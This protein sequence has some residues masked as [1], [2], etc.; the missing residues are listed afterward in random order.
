M[1]CLLAISGQYR[2]FEKTHQNILDNVIN[3][4][5]DYEFEIILNTDLENRNIFT[6][7]G[8]FN[9]TG[10]NFERKEL[11]SRLENC[12][13]K[14]L[15]HIIYYNIIEEDRSIPGSELFFKRNSLV[16]NYIEKNNLSYDRIICIRFDIEISLP[17]NLN[18]KNKLI[19]ICGEQRNTHR[20]D[21]VS[22]WDLCFLTDDII[23]LKVFLG[24]VP[25][26]SELTY[27]DLI[28][29]SSKINFVTGYLN[30][31]KDKKNI[32]EEGEGAWVLGFWRKFYDLHLLGFCTDFK[33]D[34]YAT[35][36][37]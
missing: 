27:N 7:D 34:I 9:F 24:I 19:F 29:F 18:I 31:V 15:K 21:H 3:C 25:L 16:I 5:P 6:Y 10:E 12:Y 32:I 26:S 14:Y 11:E 22:D 28:D 2:T 37:R 8:K 4:N 1:K 23:T 30:L 13:G 35:I 36:V 33:R 17:V 20:I